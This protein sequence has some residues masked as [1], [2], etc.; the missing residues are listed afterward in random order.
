MPRS[1]NIDGGKKIQGIDF[2]VSVCRAKIKNYQESIRKIKKMSGMYGPIG[3][4]EMD[5]SGLPRAGF[6]HMDFPDALAAIAK[7]EECIEKEKE[8]IRRLQRRRKNLINAAERLEGIEQMVFVCRS[9][10]D[11]T[12]E[13]AAEAV[14]ISVRHLQRIERKIRDGVDIFSL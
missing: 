1:I 2:Q 12:Q 6:T 9:I 4:G 10:H 7:N 5:Y 11:M 8:L 14:G 3:I 13:A